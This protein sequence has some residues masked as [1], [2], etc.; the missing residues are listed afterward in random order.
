MC[1]VIKGNNNLRKAFK[2]LIKECVGLYR[3]TIFTP[4]LTLIKTDVKIPK[5]KIIYFERKKF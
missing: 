2:K 1:I 4:R 5:T 3:K